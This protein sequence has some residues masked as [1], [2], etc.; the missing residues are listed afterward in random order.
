MEGLGL[1][2]GGLDC[3]GEGL[4]NVK[5]GGGG[6]RLGGGGTGFDNM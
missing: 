1:G 5:G 4:D 6:Q 3:R 2:G